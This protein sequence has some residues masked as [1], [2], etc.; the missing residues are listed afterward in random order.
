M[1]PLSDVNPFPRS[2]ALGQTRKYQL[3]PRSPLP[4]VPRGHGAAKEITTAAGEGILA[5]GTARLRGALCHR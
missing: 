2:A 4:D 5:F 3:S 1:P